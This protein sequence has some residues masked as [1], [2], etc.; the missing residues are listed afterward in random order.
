MDTAI[1][2][3]AVRGQLRLWQLA[4]AAQEW[5]VEAASRDEEDRRFAGIWIF[6][7][8]IIIAAAVAWVYCRSKGY[9]GFSGGLSVKRGPWG[10]TLGT[11][12]ECY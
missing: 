1:M 10:I 3:L 4:E 5:L 6:V 9:R 11:S 8:G 12:L 2:E 7:V